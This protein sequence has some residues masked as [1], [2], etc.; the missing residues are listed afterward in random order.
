M[1]LLYS[2]LILVSHMT[3]CDT[4][5]F[6]HFYFY[7]HNYLFTIYL[8]VYLYLLVFLSI[9]LSIYLFIYLSMYL[10]LYLFIYLFIYL[11]VCLSIYVSIFLIFIYHRGESGDYRVNHNNTHMGC[12][13]YWCGRRCTANSGSHYND[14]VV[15]MLNTSRNNGKKRKL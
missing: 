11:L 15:F 9:Y 4:L 10:S 6:I 14:Y 3:S 8:F 1:L 13:Y 5:T 7:Q 12:Y 2:L